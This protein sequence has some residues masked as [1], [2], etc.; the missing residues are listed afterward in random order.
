MLYRAIKEKHEI[1]LLD[2]KAKIGQRAAEH[3]IM[4]MYNLSFF[5]NLSGL[6]MCTEQIY[7]QGVEEQ[8]Q[9]KSE[10]LKLKKKDTSGYA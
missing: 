10:L 3:G 7:S 8:A 1:L 4:A 5:K 6:C 2:K 9:Y